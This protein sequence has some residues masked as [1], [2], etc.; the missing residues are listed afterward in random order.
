MKKL[1]NLA[2]AIL[3]FATLSG[4][5]EK[6]EKQQAQEIECLELTG[7]KYCRNEYE[8]QAAA[9]RSMNNYNYRDMNYGPTPPGSYHNYYGNPQYGSWGNDGQ[10][11]FHDPYSQQAS[12]TNS[13][14]LG[15]GLGG[16]AAYALTK[17]D[18]SRSNPK[19]WTDS[20]R[21]VKQPIGKDGKSISQAEYKKRMAQSKKDQAKHK[22]K[23]KADNA[24][25]Q[26]QL[27]SEKQKNLKKVKAEQLAKK[28]QQTN[29]TKAQQKPTQSAIDQKK[30]ELKAK[31]AQRQADRAAGKQ[32]GSKMAQNEQRLK[33]QKQPQKQVL[34]LKKPKYEQPKLN[35]RKPPRPAPKAQSRSSSRVKPSTS[36][37]TK[38]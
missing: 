24:K 31:Q 28:Q 3:V 8:Q 25:L 2:S 30:A 36:R 14:L 26:K 9:Q 29:T 27:A 1:V 21:D 37:R 10:Y 19:G 18:W 33:Q 22:E 11:R 7:D 5:G 15:A 6:S 20:V 12:Q 23:L 4:C 35:L 16:L 32:P 34:S 13:F 38:K 17:N